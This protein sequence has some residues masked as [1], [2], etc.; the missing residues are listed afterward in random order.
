[1][2]FRAIEPVQITGLQSGPADFSLWNEDINLTSF[3]TIPAPATAVLFYIV[4]DSSNSWVAALRHAN[5]SA[6]IVSTTNYTGGRL[7]HF[8][9]TL[10][11]SSGSIF[12]FYTQVNTSIKFFVAGFFHDVTVLEP[13]NYISN[14]TSTN[15]WQTKTISEVPNGTTF[16]INGNSRGTSNRW[17]SVGGTTEYPFFG[18]LAFV[19]VDSNKQFQANVDSSSAVGV[20]GYGSGDWVKFVSTLSGNSMANNVWSANSNW[21]DYP[22]LYPN[23]TGIVPFTD[24]INVGAGWNTGTSVFFRKKGASWSIARAGTS[25]VGG[26]IVDVDSSGTFQY[27]LE[28]VSSNAGS[29]VVASYFTETVPDYT[30]TD[31]NT[32]E[33]VVAGQDSVVFSGRGLSTVNKIR[34]ASNTR[35]ISK[36]VTS[37]NATTVIASIPTDSELFNSN[38]AFGNITFS[39]E[40][41]GNAVANLSGTLALSE[42]YGQHDVINVSQ[43]TNINTIYFAQ[44]PAVKVGDKIAHDSITKTYGWG[45]TIDSNGFISVSSTYSTQSDNLSYKIYSTEFQEWSTPGTV[46]LQTPYINARANSVRVA[47]SVDGKRYSKYPS[48]DRYIYDPT[49]IV[50]NQA[51]LDAQLAKTDSQ[52]QYS[53]IGLTYN[54]T[55]YTI[56]TVQLQNRRFTGNLAIVSYGAQQARLNEITLSN[57]TNFMLYNVNVYATTATGGDVITVQNCE[58]IVIDTCVLNTDKYAKASGTPGAPYTF[59]GVGGTL[60]S[61]VIIKNT[62]IFNVFRGISVSGSNNWSIL[63]NYITPQ[64]GS[65]IQYLG[66]NSNFVV[67]LNHMHEQSYVPYPTDPDAINDPHQSMIS[68]RSNNISILQNHFHNMGTS[69][70]IMFYQPDVTGGSNNYCNITI[71]NNAIYDVKN[72]FVLRMYNLGSNIVVRNN[73]LAG[74]ARLDPG[75]GCADGYTPDSRYRFETSLLVH[76]Y[77]TG[78]TDASGLSLYNNILVGR[79]DVASSAVEANNIIWAWYD[80]GADISTSP[81]GT[82]KI[83]TSA[84]LGCDLAPN[85][86]ESTAFFSTTHNYKYLSSAPDN[87]TLAAGSEGKNYGSATNQP[88]TSL[89]TIGA[90]GFLI[91]NGTARSSSAKDV[92][93]YQS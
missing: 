28:N 49:V 73:L 25:V 57:T 4:N 30:L 33:S 32:T 22:I 90:D 86:F 85:I 70:G 41:S 61:N 63:R 10:E 54:S 12:D 7:S 1:M 82:S 43:N 16:I 11:G 36:N 24:R 45:A 80:D 71:E 17:R 92:G 8:I 50:T 2:G 19:G 68:I 87:W 76:S 14:P 34:I 83:K 64:S 35:S 81:S 89:G 9:A 38:V 91:D 18:S 74:K 55:P 62:R 23:V 47:K 78:V 26:F 53:V 60:S 66:N 39:V 48:G 79:L 69:S 65:G 40:V 20:I 5:S 29:V 77:G 3:T 88:S 59:D 27:W 52:L 75:A 56:S 42:Q 21:N 46:V 67:R 58:S 15:I 84:Y 44:I 13:Q 51:Q 72:N 37:A 93:P 6:N 31:V